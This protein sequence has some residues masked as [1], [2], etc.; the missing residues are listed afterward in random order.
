MNF[1]K[2]VIRNEFPAPGKSMAVF[3]ET[4][5]NK[6]LPD[7][8]FAPPEIIDLISSDEDDNNNVNALSDEDDYDINALING[9]STS[10]LI[11][12]ND[13]QDQDP[14][15]ENEDPVDRNEVNHNQ[16][17]STQADE[18]FQHIPFINDNDHPDTS[19]LSTESSTIREQVDMEVSDGLSDTEI[20]PNAFMSWNLPP[21]ASTPVNK[22]QKRVRFNLPQSESHK[23]VKS[24]HTHTTPST[25]ESSNELN[26]LATSSDHEKSP[27]AKKRKSF[28]KTPR[29]PNND[30]DK[31][32]ANYKTKTNKLVASSA[33]AKPSEE[34]ARD[35]FTVPYK[36]KNEA[37]IRNLTVEQEKAKLDKIRA[38]LNN[39]VMNQQG[40]PPQI[41]IVKCKKK[42]KVK[43]P[44]K[45][46]NGNPSKKYF[47]PPPKKFLSS[48]V[49]E[50][51]VRDR[52]DAR[53]ER[54]AD[55]Y[56]TDDN[57]EVDEELK[58]FLELMSPEKKSKNKK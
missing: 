25:S 40:G 16:D 17:V 35:T 31:S 11:T 42:G 49:K 47:K 14:V 5:L 37:N 53:I 4:F 58:P 57:Y 39:Q 44:K 34:T 21:R 55:E 7:S 23:G 41:E 52:D 43:L 15:N 1:A 13:N 3:V 24:S 20:D 32:I 22:H 50:R 45:V 27:E 29:K 9:L 26:I 36:H 54:L 18:N 33:Y 38:R 2:A 10:G 51:L 56:S 28:P 12:N 19:P 48:E 46:H 6:H 30:P 8:L